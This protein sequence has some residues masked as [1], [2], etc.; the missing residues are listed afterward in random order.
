[1]NFAKT[2]VDAQHKLATLLYTDWRGDYK[3]CLAQY[4]TGA[5]RFFIG[6]TDDIA[7]HFLASETISGIFQFINLDENVMFVLDLECYPP[8]S[9]IQDLVETFKLC[10]A[11]DRGR[12]PIQTE[13]SDQ[14][15]SQYIT[16]FINGVVE[17]VHFIIVR[18]VLR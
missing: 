6:A 10:G 12:Q 1:M 9:G 7:D 8:T 17:F 15:Q 2:L 14:N 18:C 13:Q 3:I 11:G 16:T 4:G 5:Y